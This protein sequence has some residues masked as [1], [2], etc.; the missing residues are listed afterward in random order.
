MATLSLGRGDQHLPLPWF[1]EVHLHQLRASRGQGHTNCPLTL[2]GGT[3]RSPEPGGP[4]QKSPAPF[5]YTWGSR[6][7]GASDLEGAVAHRAMGTR[8]GRGPKRP[9]QGRGPA[10]PEEAWSQHW[11]SLEED[12]PMGRRKNFKILQPGLHFSWA[13]GGWGQCRER[14]V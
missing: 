1:R 3:L 9:P 8:E 5:A 10:F 4:S 6:S 7:P 2:L 12:S 14:D 13:P 11:L